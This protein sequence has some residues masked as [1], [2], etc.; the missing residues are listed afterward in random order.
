MPTA[1]RKLNAYQ[2][3]RTS[4]RQIRD[5]FLGAVHEVEVTHTSFE[6]AVVLMTA[7]RLRAKLRRARKE[8]HNG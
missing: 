8:A 6:G 2:F 7:E 4:A 3:Q 1:T 5:V